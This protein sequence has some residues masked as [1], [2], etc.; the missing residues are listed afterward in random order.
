MATPSTRSDGQHRGGC[1]CSRC[2][3]AN[4]QEVRGRWPKEDQSRDV[5]SGSLAKNYYATKNLVG[6]RHVIANLEKAMQAVFNFA[7][8]GEELDNSIWIVHILLGRMI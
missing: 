4:Q 5:G 1:Y 7:G 3:G 8:G 2:L 6:E